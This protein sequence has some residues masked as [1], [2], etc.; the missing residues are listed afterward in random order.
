MFNAGQVRNIHFPFDVEIDTAMCVAS[1]MV[2]ELD[3]TD[4]DVTKIAEMIDAAILALVPEWKPGVAID[5]TCCDGEDV[6]NE[7]NDGMV[8]VHD[9]MKNVSSEG[10]IEENPSYSAR[11]ETVSPSRVEGLMYGRF[12]EVTYQCHRSE[13]PTQEAEEC[14][15]SSEASEVSHDA[16][17]SLT[18]SMSSHEYQILLPMNKPAFEECS[19]VT[20][21][22]RESTTTVAFTE[23]VE[24][25]WKAGYANFVHKIWED[26]VHLHPCD[27][28]DDDNGVA[29]VFGPSLQPECYQQE[30]NGQELM[31]KLPVLQQGLNG[32][33]D[34]VS[35]EL[36]ELEVRHQQEMQELQ[37]KHEAARTEIKNRWLQKKKVKYDDDDEHP[38]LNCECG[39]R[40]DILEGLEN[41]LQ[42]LRVEEET[43]CG[44]QTTLPCHYG[45]FN[46]S[47][48]S[49]DDLS[50]FE[51]ET[52][53]SHGV[54][55]ESTNLLSSVETVYF[56]SA[57]EVKS[58][59][60]QDAM[61]VLLFLQNFGI[62]K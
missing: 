43:P 31:S 19:G 26:I 38:T 44:F 55:E 18:D 10:T 34:D 4:Q 41:G 35:Q 49:F 59:E 25:K 46:S 11:E 33:D 27:G 1:E 52:P 61:E 14:T 32:D 51:Q 13:I 5:E 47:I 15:A 37:R 23:L 57:A 29:G 39:N 24:S 22:T 58:E 42:S 6:D 48:T 28:V 2:A 45:S 17:W 40:S 56:P 60:G 12:E 30:V 36:A 3:L 53:R 20:M 50:S 7:G 16:D 54:F 62:H 9:P 8:G 21:N